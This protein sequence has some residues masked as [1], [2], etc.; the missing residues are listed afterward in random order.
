MAE[1]DFLVGLA[2]ERIK[3]ELL[4]QVKE[5]I[6]EEQDA[7]DI[8]RRRADYCRIGYPWIS[9]IYDHVREEEEHHL[10]EFQDM[11]EGIRQLE[12]K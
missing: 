12:T 7:I 4:L 6:K 8:Y 3:K 11:A 9:E 2:G 1:M 5:S 10:K